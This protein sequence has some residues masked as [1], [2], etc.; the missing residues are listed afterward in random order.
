LLPEV[1]H[2]FIINK[3]TIASR[4][5]S[6]IINKITI[7]SRRLA[8]LKIS[9]SPTFGL[10]TKIYMIVYEKKKLKFS[11]ILYNLAMADWVRVGFFLSFFFLNR[12]PKKLK[13]WMSDKTHETFGV[14][15]IQTLIHMN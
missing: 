4:S 10:C 13:I 6:F 14:Y 5:Y 3:I 15:E 11:A 9:A 8:D 2:S 12:L 7:T 1:I